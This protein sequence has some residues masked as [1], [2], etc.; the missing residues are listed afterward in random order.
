MTF[1]RKSVAGVLLA[2]LAAAAA[3]AGTWYWLRNPGKPQ[4]TTARVTR[5]DIDATIAATGNCNA[6]VTVQ[7]GSQAIG[8]VIE[9]PL[10]PGLGEP[11]SGAEGDDEFE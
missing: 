2:T 8:G 7:V 5:G 11:V 6:V 4:F 9:L 10:A 3:V 1:T